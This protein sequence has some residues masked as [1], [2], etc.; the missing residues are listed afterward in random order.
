MRAQ[1][2]QSLDWLILSDIRVQNWTY[3]FI[4]F[5]SEDWF[6]KMLKHGMLQSDLF[7]FPFLLLSAT[8][9][10]L[11]LK[12]TVHV[13]QI[14]GNLYGEKSWISQD[15]CRFSH[16]TPYWTS[17]LFYAGISYPIPKRILLQWRIYSLSLQGFN[18]LNFGIASGWCWHMYRFGNCTV[19]GKRS[20]NKLARKIYGGLL[21]THTDENCFIIFVGQQSKTFWSCSKI[22]LS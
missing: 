6:R 11:R 20:N 9:F 3:V 21:A 22:S 10:Q 15:S 17:I 4:L 14:S 16:P 12:R 19:H 13:L 8:C 2:I 18:S 5:M 7:A 1:L